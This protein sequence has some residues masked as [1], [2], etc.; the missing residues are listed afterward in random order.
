MNFENKNVLS[1]IILFLCMYKVPP[2]PNFLVLCVMMLIFDLYLYKFN[3]DRC[4]YVYTTIILLPLDIY[5]L[6]F[7]DQLNLIAVKNKLYN[8]FSYVINHKN[9]KT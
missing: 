7:C 4:M 3:F 6:Y 9:M 1:L 2:L 8:N 5:T